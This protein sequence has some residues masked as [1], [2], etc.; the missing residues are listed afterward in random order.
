[1]NDV[2][3]TFQNKGAKCTQECFSNKPEIKRKK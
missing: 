1:M 3:Q 2:N